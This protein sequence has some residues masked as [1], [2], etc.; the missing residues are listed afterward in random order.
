MDALQ[1]A[2]QQQ[3]DSQ[4]R[5][6]TNQ[7]LKA[8]LLA[9]LWERL[10]RPVVFISADNQVLNHLQLALETLWGHD[11]TT[12]RLVRYPSEFFSPYDLAVTPSTVLRDHYQVLQQL[13]SGQPR[14]FFMNVRNLVS[15]FPCWS[16]RQQ[17]GIHLQPDMELAPD[18][19]VQR[20]LAM[21]Y[22][23]NALIVE[24]G[25][26]SRRG[27][28]VD[29]YP[30]NTQPLRVSFFG[31]TVEF[32]REID[33]E[34]QRS[35]RTLEAASILPRSA[36]VLTEAHRQQLPH[37]MRTA[38]QG[39][40]K[41]LKGEGLDGLTITLEN[42]IQ[43]MEQEFWAD[44]LD[45]YAPL[46]HH[47]WTSLGECLPDNALLVLD[48]WTTLTNQLEGLCDRLQHQLEEGIVKGRLLDLNQRLHLTLEEALGSLKPAGGARLVL[49]PFP[50]EGEESA[51]SVAL[52][53]LQ[54]EPSERFQADLPKAIAYLRQKRADGF[55]VLVS[56]DYPQRVLDLCKENDLPAVYWPENGQAMPPGWV[57]GSGLPGRDVLITRKG[58]PDGFLIQAPALLH[59]TD[60]ELFGRLRARR[61]VQTDG[62]RGKRNDDIDTI[63][64]IS[65]LRPGDYVVHVKHG[66]GQFVELSQI[67]L[68]GETREYLTLQYKGKDRLYVPVDQ[69]N[70]LSR[71]RGA[72]EAKPQLSK[73]GGADWSRVKKKVTQSIQS[74]AN[75]LVALYAA[76]QQVKGHAFD[77]DTPWQVEMEEAFPFQETPDQWQAIL[78]TKKDMESE[79]PMD[80]LICGDVG[81][82]KT[83]VAL[84]AVFK[85]ILNGKQ[86]AVLV[87]TT[88]LAQQHFNTL[89][90]RFQPYG[91]KVG[92]LSRFR[93]PAEQKEL[94]QRLREG[95]CD[96][97][98]GTHRLL[99]KD[100][101]FKDL[102]LLVI[103]EEHRFGVSHK[104][105]I[106]QMR[107][108]VDVLTMSATPIPRTLYMSISGVREMSLI[109]TPPVNRL[110][111]QTFVGPYNPAQ[112]R[113]AILQEVDRGGQVYY[114]HN[115]VN[116][117]YGV[118][119]QVRQLVPEVRVAVAHG[120]LSP[121]DLETVM[122]DFASQQYDVLLCTTIVESGVDIPNANTL[123]MDDADRYGLAQL[124]QIR[125]RV[126]RSEQQAYAYLY[127]PPDR[128]LT[129]DAK[130]RLRAIREFTALGSG[131]HIA[132][133]DMEI[134]G[135]GNILGAEQHGHMIQVGFDLYCDLLNQAVEAAQQGK[136]HIEE[137][138]EPSVIDLNVTAFIP[139]KWVGDQDVKLSE[140]KRLAA[141]DSE[142]GL[143]VV[144][145]EWQDRFG[146]VP[147]QAKQLLQL[148]RLRV[149]ATALTIPLVRM[150]DEHLRISVPFGLQDWMR[151]QGQ[152]KTK[153]ASKL[154]WV[155]PVR[156]SSEA[157]G[158]P[159]LLL[160]HATLDAQTLVKFLLE[161]FT[162][163]KQLGG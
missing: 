90:E 24:P 70:L 153:L 8:L 13:A 152:L 105:K 138:P 47:D 17:H 144:E 1:R 132:M 33:P 2:L 35:V 146:P 104:E 141:I 98:V 145:A 123:I 11:A 25:D 39:Q 75:E 40:S 72:G 108:H 86:A 31:D 157:G 133:R 52:P 131:Y 87:P 117:I 67:K 71:Y 122:L 4:L 84:R 45:Y 148:A 30:I 115:R 158:V 136:S 137:R 14:L 110:P 130:N 57:A 3:R 102:G 119:E 61:M 60:A 89:A 74:I 142:K 77:P 10:N 93:S 134:R 151:L 159:T 34:S 149:L 135:V 64:S 23:T 120:Q 103:D 66:I 27:D 100:V 41:A 36:L 48:D 69:V 95:Q 129:D 150:D 51:A 112:V 85:S 59:L 50:V 68:D 143:D 140:Y 53:R 21:G 12:Q 99:Q 56:T 16:D 160:K 26:I 20:C 6:L 118:A 73:I 19:L 80:R 18:E 22:H 139:E 82:G 121:T 32:V 109:N 38:L 163:L 125:G 63:Q 92:L 46:V 62:R 55:N 78:D 114:L 54:V 5:Q 113:M 37:A 107:T 127:Y 44:G 161:L 126:G 154:R 128:Q 9:L 83:E 28:I 97:V 29:V 156:S 147:P 76:R 111:V 91:V 43:A 81:F 162:E 155:A 42:Q 88:I 96:V 94:L 101:Q 49:D 7:S 124:Y 116:T 58:L 106:K 79:R 15:R 65:E